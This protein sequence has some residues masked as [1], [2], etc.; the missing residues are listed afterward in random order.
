MQLLKQSPQMDCINIT[1]EAIESLINDGF[2]EII[3][4]IIPKIIP[5][6]C[7]GDHEQKLSIKENCDVYCDVCNKPI[8]AHGWHE[9]MID[10]FR[11]KFLRDAEEF[12][13][14]APHGSYL[15]RIWHPELYSDNKEFFG[16]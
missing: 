3:S 9:K 6:F 10:S 7:L 1:D 11:E 2:I 15:H 8:P 14:T 12:H 16:R 4:E 5:D 13:Y